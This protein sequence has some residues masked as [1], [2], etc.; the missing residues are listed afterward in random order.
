[1]EKQTEEILI[2]CTAAA[3]FVYAAVLYMNKM[4]IF[5]YEEITLVYRLT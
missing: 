4:L 5:E 2:C 1:M 3:K